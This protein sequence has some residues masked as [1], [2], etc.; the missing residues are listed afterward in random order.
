MW[1]YGVSIWWHSSRLFVKD[2]FRQKQP[3][4]YQLVVFR[5]PPPP[6]PSLIFPWDSCSRLGKDKTTLRPNYSQLHQLLK[7]IIRKQLCQQPAAAWRLLLP[8]QT[9]PVKPT[10]FSRGKDSPPVWM[11]AHEIPVPFSF[12]SAMFTSWLAL[13]MAVGQANRSWLLSWSQWERRKSH[14]EVINK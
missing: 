11:A 3:S 8:F 2:L 7:R 10:R 1:S 14:L 13:K 4:A 12:R 6:S 5:Q 9:I